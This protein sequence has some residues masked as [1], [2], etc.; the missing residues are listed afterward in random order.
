M[1]G[2]MQRVFLVRHAMRQDNEDKSWGQTAA[3]PDDPPLS[4]TGRVQARETGRYLKDKGITAL[5]C[6]P[7]L[8]AIQ[9]AQMVSEEIGVR[10]RVENA[11]S[12]WLNPKWFEQ[13]PELTPLEET[14]AACSALDLSY[15]SRVELAYP[16]ANEQVDVYQRLQSFLEWLEAA[17]A[18]NVVLVGHG[19]SVTQAARALCGPMHD[20]DAKLASVTE[21]VRV[22]G[23]WRD[24]GSTQKHLSIVIS[25]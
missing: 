25:E 8:R 3:R 12:E 5:Y 24:Q 15:R 21:I 18:G 2:D 1:G 9:T 7:F 14:R 13:R 4:P 19:A 17:E 23:A 16:E 6:S 11:L 22:D 10:I 20:L